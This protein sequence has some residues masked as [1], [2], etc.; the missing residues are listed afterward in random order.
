MHGLATPSRAVGKWPTFFGFRRQ[1][2]G[3]TNFASVL[4]YNRFLVHRAFSQQKRIAYPLEKR[5]Q[6]GESAAPRWNP[7]F[8]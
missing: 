4:Q 1:S 3:T 5:S 8:R 2:A 6:N 7:D